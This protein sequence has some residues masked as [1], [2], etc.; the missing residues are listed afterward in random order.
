MKTMSL[1]KSPLPPEKKVQCDEGKFFSLGTYCHV[2]T[3]L[4][5]V[6]RL[7]ARPRL[8]QIN[9]RMISAGHFRYQWHT[10]FVSFESSKCHHQSS[11]SVK[12]DCQGFCNRNLVCF[13]F[14]VTSVSLKKKSIYLNNFKKIK[15]RD[16]INKIICFPSACLCFRKLMFY[17]ARR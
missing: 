9:P 7:W 13:F 3:N 2:W 16:V 17:T 15:W 14:P 1:G 11:D 8:Y 6:N 5:L 4:N 10:S 12:A